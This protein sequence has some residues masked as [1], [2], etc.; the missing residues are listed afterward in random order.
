MLN[1]AALGRFKKIGFLFLATIFGSSFLWSIWPDNSRA[2]LYFSLPAV[3]GQFLYS[4]AEL[5]TILTSGLTFPEEA[6]SSC[7]LSNAREIQKF[8]LSG[9]RV[10]IKD[11]VVSVTVTTPRENVES[12]SAKIADYSFSVMLAKYNSVAEPIIEN[13]REM[14]DVIS[15]FLDKER[16][17]SDAVVAPILSSVIDN[18][19]GTHMNV[20]GQ[21]NVEPK[22]LD[23][24][25]TE[26]TRLPL[27]V[28]LFAALLL[29]VVFAGAYR[30]LV[31]IIRSK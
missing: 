29:F 1:L 14:L 28:V 8:R 7:A 23:I 10:R 12:C 18:L 20:M 24:R 16:N 22:L 26:H 4:Q 25:I 3:N 5:A 30:L 9:M 15:H 19:L 13:R 2:N 31:I 11:G 21:K 17:P 27:G 6:R